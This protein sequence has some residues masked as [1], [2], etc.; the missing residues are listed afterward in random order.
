MKISEEMELKGNCV[1]TPIYPTKLV[2]D[3]ESLELCREIS[4]FI[5]TNFCEVKPYAIF[6]GN[7]Y[8]LVEVISKR[9]DKDKAIEELLT[10]ENPDEIYTIGDG[11]TI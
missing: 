6:A 5:N 2:I 7:K 8:N 4:E 1:L 9:T 3:L 10:K 11:L